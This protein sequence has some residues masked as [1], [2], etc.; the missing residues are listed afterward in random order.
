MGSTLIRSV[1]ARDSWVFAGRAATEHRS[2]FEKVSEQKILSLIKHAAGGGGYRQLMVNKYSPSRRSPV[3]KR[4]MMRK[5]TSMKDGR[6]WW[7]WAAVSHE[8]C[9]DGQKPERT[10]QWQG[11]K[12]AC[13]IT[14]C[15]NKSNNT[16]LLKYY[17][18]L[19]LRGVMNNIFPRLPQVEHHL[20][21]TFQWKAGHL[22]F[23][24]VASLGSSLQ[25]HFSLGFL[26]YFFNFYTWHFF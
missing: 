22:G 19:S 11:G 14:G 25:T 8:P 13:G 3:R 5:P 4:L 1:K 2:L 17:S 23:C 24:A 26:I 6:S 9:N 10:F 18:S 12:A 15:I 7:R 20:L 16:R 21:F